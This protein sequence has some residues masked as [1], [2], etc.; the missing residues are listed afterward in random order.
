MASL[1]PKHVI[2][3]CTGIASL[4]SPCGVSLGGEFRWLGASAQ[5]PTVDAF[6]EAHGISANGQVVVG[7]LVPPI[8]PVGSE[9][10][11]WTRQ[12]PLGAG[13]GLLDGSSDGTLSS[14]AAATSAD[15]SVIAGSSTS[16][17]GIQAFRWTSEG[18]LTGLGGLLPQPVDGFLSEANDVSGDGEIVV[19]RGASPQGIEALLW[20]GSEGI[21]NLG[22][23]SGGSVDSAATA[24]SQDGTVVVGFSDSASGNQ[25]FRWNESEEMIG[26]GD[27]PGG[28]FESRALDVSSDGTVIVGF[29]TTESGME[30]FRWTATDGMVGL[31][32]LPGFTGGS[33][34]TA[35]SADGQLVAGVSI[36]DTG[37]QPFLWDADHGMRDITEVFGQAAELRGTDSTIVGISAD[38]TVMAGFG[39][40]PSLAPTPWI[41]VIPEPHSF[42]LLASGVVAV[43]F[44]STWSWVQSGLR[45]S[46]E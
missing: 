45:W 42:W 46:A 4:A 16:D 7:K 32:H 27:L 35:T 23:L 31:G 18:G 30:A 40:G 20:T 29:G 39:N 41:L 9:A 38:G 36:G 11:V 43:I 8:P 37:R 24:V 15:G 22:H 33:Y 1:N 19:G 26:L 21:Q 14:S 25:A 13:L 10:Y 44:R 2:L 17:Q 5:D 12:E 3:L 6:G 34:A 28:V